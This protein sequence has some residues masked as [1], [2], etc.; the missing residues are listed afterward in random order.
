MQHQQAEGDKQHNIERP[1]SHAYAALACRRRH[2]AQY[3]DMG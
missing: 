3:C 1:Y 2:A